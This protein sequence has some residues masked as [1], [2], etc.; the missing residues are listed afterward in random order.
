MA[1]IQNARVLFNSIPEGAVPDPCVTYPFC[2]SAFC[3]PAYPVP[4]DTTVYDPTPIIDVETVPL[5]GG[6]LVKTLVLSI[7]PFMR[8]MMRQPDKRSYYVRRPFSPL[9]VFLKET[10]SLDSQSVHRESSR[11]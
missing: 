1:P 2:V 3:V 9:P 4:G 8:G 10:H 7:D 5:N 6:F 11:V